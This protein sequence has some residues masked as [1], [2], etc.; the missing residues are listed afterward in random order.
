[1]PKAPWE[2]LHIDFCGPLP[3][4]EYLLV[5]IDRYSR[6][7]EVEIIRSIKA[8][9][10]IPKLHKIFA[11]HGIPH[12]IVSD[13]GP[14]F[15]SDEFNKYMKILGIEHHLV[16]PYWPQVNGE[17][18]RFNQPLKKTIQAAVVEGKIWRQE[19][20]RFL[21]QYRTTPH[22]TTKVPPSELLFNRK[23]RGK[24]PSIE[25][26]LVVY[27]HK[28]ARENET[29]SQA[30]HKSYP[31][32]RRNVKESNIEVG[33]TVLVKQKRKDK[34]S[35]RF[36]KTPYVVLYRKGTQITAENKHKHRIKRNVSHF[37]KF[38]NTA[39]CPDETES[40]LDKDPAGNY[41]DERE[42]ESE[43]AEQSEQTVNRW[44]KQARRPPESYGHPVPSSVLP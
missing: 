15:N 37:K 17:V 5:L 35:S 12:K 23:I 16:T 39:E 22:C 19:L 33:D 25:R 6:Y 14:P 20:N 7:P 30:Y 27:R 44:P 11:V 41:N 8:A 36:N 4:S 32:S 1:M 43:Q 9:C 34:F 26:K 29:K 40:E 24:L 21:L 13:N 31:D 28:E 10:V 3:S 38:E 42:S 18:E 2:T